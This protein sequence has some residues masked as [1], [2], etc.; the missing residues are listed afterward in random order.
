[1]LY[2]DRSGGIGT[3]VFSNAG[4]GASLP[5]ALPARSLSHRPVQ[6]SNDRHRALE[7]N[8]LVLP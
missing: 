2:Y 8:P 1:M 6:L 7:T 4:G 3:A 5:P